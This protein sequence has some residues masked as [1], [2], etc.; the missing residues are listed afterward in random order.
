MKTF[1]I[2]Y[3]TSDQR[4]DKFVRKV[5]N[6]A[7]ESFIYKLFRIK[8]VKVAGKPVKRDYV[9]QVGDEVKIYVT[10]AQYEQF[11]GLNKVEAMMFPYPIV[12]EDEQILMVNKPRGMLV[13]GEIGRAHV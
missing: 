3:Q 13:H 8:D 9:L 6:K 2:D 7:P 4:V 11:N 12:Y 5:L 1:T 10:D